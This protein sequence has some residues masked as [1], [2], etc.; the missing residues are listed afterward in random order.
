MEKKYEQKKKE[1]ANKIVGGE[2]HAKPYSKKME[3]VKNLEKLRKTK[4]ESRLK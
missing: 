4:T 2:I 3:G 1:L